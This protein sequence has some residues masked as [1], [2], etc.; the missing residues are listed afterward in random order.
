MTVSGPGDPVA[1]LDMVMV[2]VP[3]AVTVVPDGMS[4]P[5]T[6]IPTAIPA[7]LDTEVR[8]KEVLVGVAVGVGSFCVAASTLSGNRKKF[9]STGR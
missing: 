5:E 6:P 7:T 2:V 4:V 8:T 3:T 9:C 1:A